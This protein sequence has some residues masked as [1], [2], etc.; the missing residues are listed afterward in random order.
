M[1]VEIE[2]EQYHKTQCRYCDSKLPPPFLKLGTMALAN[3]FLFP[4]QV[5]GE[6]SCPL[7]LTRCSA[8]SL[9][10]LTHVVPKE[11]M[12]SDYLYV[13]STTRTFQKHFSKYVQSVKGKLPRNK[14]VL[15]VDIGSNDGLLLSC[16][17]KEGINAVGIEPAQNLSDQANQ[18]GRKTINRFF[19][20]ACVE[21]I[22]SEY[23]PAHVITANNVFAHIDH[24]QD[25][26]KNTLRLLRPA[27]FFVIE[28]PYLITM[29]DQLLFDMI[30]HEH[31][32]YI[33]IAS[34]NHLLNRFHMEIFCI[35]KVASHGGSLRVFI[36]KK[37]ET[38]IVS[39]DVQK[40]INLETNSDYLSETACETFAQKVQSVKEEL[41]QYIIDIKTK[42]K[43]ISAYGAPAKANTIINF[44]GLNQTQID[45]IV[46]DNPLKQ[47]RLTPGAHIPVVS[48]NHLLNQPTD[49]VIIFAWNFAKEIINNLE[50]LKRRGVQFII[51]LPKPRLIS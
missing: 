45:Y 16:F 28:F 17:Q 25:V 18:N 1:R 10:Q 29:M 27:G 20:Q 21:S 15:A 24:I 7:Q 46:D 23:G 31:L 5:E 47:N 14:N 40:F 41:L 35:E 49:Y 38:R 30:Y 48:R 32:S 33:S 44:C 26:C 43:S 37:G 4:N 12:F 22:L 13:S 50:H 42:K 6:F 19:D 36:Q 8:C 39:R 51:P 34:L 9:V 11:L 3:S 2:T